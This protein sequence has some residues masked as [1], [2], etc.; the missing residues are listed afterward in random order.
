MYLKNKVLIDR[1]SYGSTVIAI[2]PVK[3][4]VLSTY[5][6]SECLLYPK[7]KQRNNETLTTTR[8]NKKKNKS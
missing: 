5:Y 7:N 8:F 1:S 3:I 4:I 2:P 6:L